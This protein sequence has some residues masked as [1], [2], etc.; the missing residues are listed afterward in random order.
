[1]GIDKLSNHQRIT[2]RSEMISSKK[3]SEKK[4]SI[5][6]FAAAKTTVVVLAIALPLLLFSQFNEVF[7]VVVFSI[8]F[9]LVLYPAVDFF[10]NKGL[11]RFMA[12]LA[13]YACISV[14]ALIFYFAVLPLFMQQVEN[15]VVKFQKISL[16]E[17]LQ[18]IVSLIHQFAPKYE[19]NTV[20]MKG[21]IDT[22]LLKS[23]AQ[24][25]RQ[26][27]ESV[28]TLSAFGFI[29]LFVFFGIKD[30]H[31]V[32][33]KFASLV[34]NKYFEMTLN[35]FY[36]VEKQL[37]NYIRGIVLDS[38]AVGILCTIGFLAIGLDYSLILGLLIAVF[39]IVPL[40]GPA[41]GAVLPVLVAVVQYGS[42]KQAIV[43]LII[44]GIVRMLDG[45]VIRQI[46]Y[47]TL[48]SIPPLM[49][50]L[51]VALGQELM[52]VLGTILFIPIYTVLSATAKET[53]RELKSYRM[54]SM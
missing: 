28:S 18:E 14:V 20:E 3:T 24:F 53:Y 10:E 50:L 11:N 1:V 40:V 13:V 34:P 19:I 51:L 7:L 30:Y 4:F 36:R 8:A 49:I 38:A 45:W 27:V 47:K 44:F 16:E 52:G 15:L 37:S 39:N 5:F 2:E 23:V 42:I 43:P 21:K 33:K 26:I 54:T 29:P 31:S 32:Q 6:Q 17:K 41:L 48:L 35:F 9:T 46:I 25:R 22:F 12:T